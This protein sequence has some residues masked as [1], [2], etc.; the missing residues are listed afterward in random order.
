LCLVR[1][2]TIM[3]SGRHCAPLLG[4][5]I[6]GR[7]DPQESDM[8]EWTLTPKCEV[9]KDGSVKCFITTPHPEASHARQHQLHLLREF[10]MM[11][12]RAR[13]PKPPRSPKS[14]ALEIRV[15]ETD[16]CRFQS[17]FA[18]LSRF[19]LAPMK[20]D[21]CKNGKTKTRSRH[22]LYPD[23]ARS[24]RRA[25]TSTSLTDQLIEYKSK[26]EKL[27]C[28]NKPK[29]EPLRLRQKSL[30]CPA[31]LKQRSQKESSFRKECG[32][33]GCNEE[34]NCRPR[35]GNAEENIRSLP[36]LSAMLAH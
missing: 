19:A 11:P 20:E 9:V 13:N 6:Q 15:R 25:I 36:T 33:I 31:L 21:T 5:S 28:D 18:L 22:S 26:K 4:E 1:P 16:L 2:P 14:H 3:P 32:A 27:V 24:R 23:V 29:Y 7:N 17:D 8:L 12:A 35:S 34:H 30:S 10:E